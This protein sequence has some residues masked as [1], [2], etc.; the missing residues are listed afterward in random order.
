MDAREA[1]RW[2]RHD[3]EKYCGV[4]LSEKKQ[5]RSA[6][7][8]AV[9]AELVPKRYVVEAHSDHMKGY[10]VCDTSPTGWRHPHPAWRVPTRDQ[11]ERIAAIFEETS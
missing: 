10:K 5:A 3:L 4:P 2:L 7:A 1:I 6:E 8:V 9:L 11:A